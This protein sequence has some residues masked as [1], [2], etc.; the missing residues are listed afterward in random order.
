MKDI[1]IIIVL[2][3]NL[4]VIILQRL[5]IKEYEDIFLEHNGFDKEE[6]FKDE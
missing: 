6:E 3:I 5:I 4:S 2:I 1:F